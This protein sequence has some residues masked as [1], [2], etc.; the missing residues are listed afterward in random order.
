MVR[1]GP[2]GDGQN[3]RTFIKNH[4]HELYACDFMTQYTALFRTVY[5]FVVMEVSTR[6]IVLCNVTDNHARPSQATHAIPDPYPE[7]L[8]RPPTGG[9]L[10]ALPVLG[11][12]QHDYRLAAWGPSHPRAGQHADPNALCACHVHLSLCSRAHPRRQGAGRS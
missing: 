2:R 12:V 10:L 11:G 3:W 8:E 1:S 5:V 6:R 7:L 4:S 9:K